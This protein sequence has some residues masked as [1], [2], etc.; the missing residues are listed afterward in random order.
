MKSS[1]SASSHL[2]S[3]IPQLIHSL[4][5]N[6]AEMASLLDSLVQHFDLCVNAIKHTEGGFAAVKKAAT[7]NQLPDGVTVSGVIEEPGNDS[8]LEPLSDEDRRQM[9]TVLSNDAA[10]VEDVVLEL[11][12]RL[13]SMEEQHDQIQEHV[14]TLTTSYTSTIAAFT[15]LDTIGSRLPAYIASS[16]DF[17]LRWADSKAQIS[18]QM[19]E[20]ESIR[21]F[22][23][24][25][26]TSYHGLI[27]EVARRKASEEKMKAMLKKTM[28]QVRKLHD[29]DTRER[30]AF[31]RE[32]GDYLPSDL[33]PGLV[34]DAPRFEITVVGEELEA[35]GEA[36]EKIEPA[37]R[38]EKQRQR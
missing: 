21:V 18:E 16:Q 38:E 24:G 8:G 15:I 26:M 33:W 5:E 17:L 31:R 37:A 19:E 3:P 34:A 23:E 14:G 32:V 20:L 27:E 35:E 29:A 6:A 11:H 22:Y 2:E 7:D 12:Q 25:Y 10:E 30:E 28:V 1:T 13:Q 4:E 9:L 36:E